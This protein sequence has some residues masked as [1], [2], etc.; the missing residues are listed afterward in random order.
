MRLDPDFKE[1][2]N[3]ALS[4]DVK[5]MVVGG[6]AVAAHGHPRYTGGLDIW[7]LVDRENAEKLVLTLGEFGFA[8]LHLTPKD[9]MEE[10]QVI[11]LGREPLR[12]DLLTGLDGLSFSDCMDRAITVDIDRMAVPFISR[13][14]LL[15]NK[16][17]TGRPQDRADVAALDPCGSQ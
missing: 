2:I 8:E 1:F 7:I 14:D 9:F 17:A 12:I 16:R 6:Y 5:F 4:N 13:H 11:Q 3:L 10:G 15:V